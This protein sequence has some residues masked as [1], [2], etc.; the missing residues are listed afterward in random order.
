MTGNQNEKEKPSVSPEQ[1]KRMKKWKKSGNKIWNLLKGVRRG[2]VFYDQ[3][4]AQDKGIMKAAM[5][6]GKR[7]YGNIVKILS[8]KKVVL[9]E[10]Y[11]D[12]MNKIMK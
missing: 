6:D 4:T 9:R 10:E 8:D 12:L 11:L 2:E 3:L 7:T 1:V 5:K